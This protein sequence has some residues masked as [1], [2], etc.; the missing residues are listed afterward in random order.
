[1]V[2]N[3]ICY[4]YY[5]DELATYHIYLDDRFQLI[6]DFKL[7]TGLFDFVAMDSGKIFSYLDKISDLFFDQATDSDDIDEIISPITKIVLLD[8][9]NKNSVLL[10]FGMIY[11]KFLCEL[12]DGIAD[13][14]SSSLEIINR[15]AVDTNASIPAPLLSNDEVAYIHDMTTNNP[16]DIAGIV[17]TVLCDAITRK[18]QAIADDLDLILKESTSYKDYSH[19]QRLFLLDKE[20][21]LKHS[22]LASSFQT[23]FGLDE[24]FERGNPAAEILAVRTSKAPVHEL[25]DL[26]TIDDC[27]RFE[28]IQLLKANINFKTCKC[29]GFFFIPNGRSD[30]TYCDRFLPTEGKTCKEIG[31]T[32]IFADKHKDDPIHKAYTSA[33]Q[34]MYSRKRQGS[35]TKKMF[36]SWGEQARKMEQ[37][38]YSGIITISELQNWL[39]ESKKR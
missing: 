29:C 15:I 7:G 33:Y 18:Q 3:P 22:Y 17:K 1:M 16:K 12:P 36:T 6:H 2:N 8:N 39:D 24:Y 9:T 13:S 32:L 4:A 37:D 27:I 26:F 23:H 28:L 11:M 10:V 20:N 21:S 30:S 34:R 25:Y 38:C 31:A 35:L 5:K 14:I 19:L